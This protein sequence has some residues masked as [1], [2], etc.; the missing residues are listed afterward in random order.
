MIKP[1]E[2]IAVFYKDEEG[3]YQAFSPNVEGAISYG[4]TLDSA[5]KNIIEAIEGVIKTAMDKDIPGYFSYSIEYTAKK[6]EI[7]ETVNID[8]KLQVAVS[9]KIAREKSGVSQR[10]FGK[11]LGL[12][13]QSISRYE[14][15]IIIPTADK[16]LEILGA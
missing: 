2:A 14:R 1:F 4:D 11:Q 3:Y 12:T 13:Q 6:G 5:R 8:R 16:F 10:E 15:G 9:I 7:V